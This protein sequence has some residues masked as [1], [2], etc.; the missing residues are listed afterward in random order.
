MLRAPN[1]MSEGNIR[2]R[3]APTLFDMLI[4]LLFRCLWLAIDAPNF[5][6]GYTVHIVFMSLALLASTIIAIWTIVVGQ[7]LRGRLHDLIPPFTHA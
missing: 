2:L 5:A 4:R 1:P 6:K 3:Q 7:Q